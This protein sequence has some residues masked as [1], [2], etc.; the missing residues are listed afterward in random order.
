MLSYQTVEPHTL[1]LLKGL[2]SEPLFGSLRLVG[3]TALALQYGHRSSIDLDFFGNIE[4]D[5]ETIKDI[6]R[7]YGK[8]LVIKESK[9]IKIYQ[10]DGVKVDIVN[11]S[12]PWID[13]PII[14]DGIILASPK[15]IASMK[16][17]AIEGRGT[18]KDFIDMYFLLQ[19][20]DLREIFTF[21][22]NKYP[23]NSIFRALMSL[24]Y[25]DD[26]ENQFMPKMFSSISWEDVKNYISVQVELYSKGKRPKMAY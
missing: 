24:S 13:T 8:L 18:K 14:E 21:Y 20:Y 22:Q 5:A 4:S 23:E 2:M 3:G 7:K 17:N 19:H 10:L 1:E 9:N 12:Y 11:Y 15:D 6:L 25:F 16:V 26:A